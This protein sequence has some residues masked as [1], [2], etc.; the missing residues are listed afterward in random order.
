L[1]EVVDLAPGGRQPSD[2]FP[3]VTRMTWK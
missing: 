3:V 1:A 2:H